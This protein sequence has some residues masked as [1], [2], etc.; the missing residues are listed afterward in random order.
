MTLLSQ[1]REPFRFHLVGEDVVD[2]G[3]VAFAFGFEPV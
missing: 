2:A 3:E 1:P